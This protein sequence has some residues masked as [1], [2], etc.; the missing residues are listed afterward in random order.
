MSLRLDYCSTEAARFACEKWHYSKSI[1]FG[2][3]VKIG[4]W[5]DGRFIG[6]IIFAQGANYNIGRPYQL[7][8][9]EVCELCRVALTHHKAPVS[10]IVSISLKM[11]KKACPALRAVIS[12]ADADEGHHG[13]IYQAGN[14]IYQG[15]S[16]SESKNFLIDGRKI[17]P[18]MVA[19]IFGTNR[20]DA[21]KK[22]CKTF[23]VIKSKGKHKYIMPLDNKM[24]GI[25]EKKALPYPKRAVS[26]EGDT[27][28]NQMEEGGSI[29]TT[30]LL[31]VE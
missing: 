29:P 25:I 24:A 7:A 30:A 16:N 10:R 8:M 28:I 2:K 12:Y 9:T 1:P 3:S 21:I 22:K 19:D 26:V 31:E 23:E 13:G 17:H 11:L 5:E 4:V 18:R 6:A 15:L 20:I 27:T 14:W